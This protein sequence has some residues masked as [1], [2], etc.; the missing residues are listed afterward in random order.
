MIEAALA[1]RGRTV[2]E[3]VIFINTP[4]RRDSDA[5]RFRENGEQLLNPSVMQASPQALTDG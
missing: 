2:A 3:A 1:G 4:Q 5:G